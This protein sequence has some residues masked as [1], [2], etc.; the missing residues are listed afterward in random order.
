MNIKTDLSG[1]WNMSSPQMPGK[2]IPAE[3]PGDN[4]SAL[5]AA[6][7]IPD[8]YYGRNEIIVQ[9]YRKYQ[10]SFKRDFD[11]TS[12]MLNKKYIFLEVSMADTF[13]EC[14]VNGKKVFKGQNAFCA[15][16]PE[17]KKLLKEGSNSIEFI[18]QPA[19][20]ELE[21][22]AKNLPTKYPMNPVCKVPNMNLARKVHCHG[23]WDWG[24]TLM[25]SGIYDP[26]ILNCTDH[27]RIE[28]IYVSQ[29]HEK[30]SVKVAAYADIYCEK[31]EK[32]VVTFK[33]NG[34]IREVKAALKT[35]KNT[36]KTDFIVKNPRLWWPAGYG[37][38][39]LYELEVATP[40]SSMSKNIGLRDVQVIH[41]KD[42]IGAS[43]S[44][45][46]NGIDIFAKGANWIPCDAMPSRQTPE[47]YE[48]LIDSSLLANMNMLRIWGGGQYE[49]EIFYDLC[50]KKGIMV[51]HDMMFSCSIYPSTEEF[52][53]N[54]TCE[55]EYQIPRLKSHPCIVMW[56]GDNEL[57]GATGWYGPQ[58]KTKWLLNFDRLNHAIDKVVTELDPDRVFWPSSPCGGPDNLL[59]DGW[60]DDTC[61]D[62]HYWTVWQEANRLE[63]YYDVKPRFCSEFGFMAFP[64]MDN[65]RKFCPEDQMNVSSPVMDLHQKNFRGNAAMIGMFGYYFRM[66]ESFAGMVYLSQL[67]QAIAI[68][69][70]VEFWRTLKPR[71][72]GTL[73]WQLNDDW[74][75]VSLS[76]IDY[77]G[78]WRQLQYHAKR[79]FEPVFGVMYP[80]KGGIYQ[81]Y[82]V[83]DLTVKAKTV[84][85]VDVIDMDGKVVETMNFKATLTPN[86]SRC[87]KTFKKGDL[88]KYPETETIFVIR[89]TAEAEVGNFEHENVFFRKPYK[90]YELPKCN[91]KAAVKEAGDELY[92]TLTT[93]KPAF[94][95]ML[96]APNVNG[97]F[98]DNSFLLVPGRKKIVKFT[99]EE[100]ISAKELEKSLFL[101]CLNL[102]H[103]K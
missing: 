53:E 34:E 70:A 20:T 88:D 99:S 75:A 80:E 101:E 36:V 35:G 9:K 54:V 51:W 71:C 43:F 65:I 4:Y 12:E 63:A 10:W 49:K 92:I 47:R 60:H 45:R 100:K 102:N 78:K 1:I 26:V 24:I 96:D 58:N 31:D 74:S 68:K 79:F 59:I 83:S 30:N 16:R 82:A 2:I 37:N 42:E 11:V 55:L 22:Y 15:Y 66:P 94:F 52:I 57:I 48:N 29:K 72:M 61:G 21:K 13:V 46:I 97:L 27:G 14:Q 89:T 19:E 25:V 103:L 98:N 33:F 87:I 3:L 39:E 67:Q 17:I 85:S 76:S 28:T 77:D 6:D 40:D 7:I 50:D 23:G 90:A 73:F 5:L 8:P 93:D 86:E 81:L 18:I 84:V 64:S 91:I 95:V 56:C 69:M 38:P 44:F 32:T 62:M 41:E